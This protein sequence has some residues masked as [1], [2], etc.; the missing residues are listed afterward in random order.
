VHWQ[1]EQHL[2]ETAH[3]I[4]TDTYLQDKPTPNIPVQHH[5]H[6]YEQSNTLYTTH[7]HQ[8]TAVWHWIISTR[9]IPIKIRKYTLISH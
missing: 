5:T 1:A 9:I 3:G 6:L 2:S 4:T 7:L 8:Y